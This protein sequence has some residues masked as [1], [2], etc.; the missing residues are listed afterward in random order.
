MEK[1]LENI[2]IGVLISSFLGAYLGLPGHQSIFLFR[3]LL[4]LHVI[5]FVFFGIKEWN[6]LFNLRYFFLLLGI[7]LIGNCYTLFWVIERGEALRYIYYVME[8]CYIIFL[9]IYYISLKKNYC[10]FVKVLIAFYLIAIIIGL[11][12]VFIGWHLP[13]SGSVFYETSTSQYQPTAFLFNTNDYAMFLAIFLPL[14]FYELWESYNSF[15]NQCLAI[16]VLLLSVFLVITTYSRLGIVTIF[17]EFLVIFWC[18][19]RKSAIFVLFT[20]SIYFFIDSF[21]QQGLLANIKNIII[22]SFTTKDASTDDRMN[23]YQISWEIIRDS[24][25]IGIGAGNVPIQIHNY[26]TGNETTENLYRAPHNFWLETIG[27]IGFFAASIIIFIIIM[28]ILSIRIWWINRN[29]KQT[30]KYFIPIM[31]VIVFCISSVALST[32]IEKRYLWLALGVALGMIDSNF[33][34]SEREG[35]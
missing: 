4:V 10:F 21:F 11:I 7:W 23:L 16:L 26:L 24:H 27:G 1:I 6:R 34:K 12:E 29:V 9:I 3:I 25:F 17:V 8:A 18:Y 20:M 28:I 19:L 22:S 2:G 5:M 35:V 33:I 30:I 31:I 15:W 32:I 13:L 14:V